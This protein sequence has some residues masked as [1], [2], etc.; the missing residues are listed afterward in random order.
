[1]VV[2]L[3]V[4]AECFDFLLGVTAEAIDTDH[5]GQTKLLNRVNMF[6]H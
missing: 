4:L 2:V 1:M 6:L 3:T 5:I